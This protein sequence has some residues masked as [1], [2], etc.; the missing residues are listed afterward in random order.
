MTE[1]AL[2]WL[3]KT[4]TLGMG[5]REWVERDPDFDFVRDDPRFQALAN[6]LT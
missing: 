3:A 6:K 5:A 4:F 2:V 1:E